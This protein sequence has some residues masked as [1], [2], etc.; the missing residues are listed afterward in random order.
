MSSH[1]VYNSAT[2]AAIRR[3]KQTTPHGLL[4]VGPTGVGLMTAAQDIAGT[5]IAGVISPTT[6]DGEP[7]SEKGTIRVEQIR[8]LYRQTRTIAS[9]D[10]VYI[11][12]QADT[13]NHS[14][15]NA[16][17]KLLEEPNEHIKFILLAHKPQL[18]LATVLS[19]VQ[20]VTVL[21]IDHT[22]S[23][24]LLNSLGITDESTIQKMLFLA[25]GLPGELT[26]LVEDT[27][28]FS[29]QAKN[30]GDARILL[31]GSAY[32]KVVLIHNYATDRVA[33]LTLLQSALIIMKR[34]L[35]SAPTK[36]LIER[37]EQY[38]AAHSAISAN[39]NVRIHLLS[40]VV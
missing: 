32:E 14:A 37:C 26:R 12:D 6:V 33:A 39:G 27:A 34:S 40:L 7:D 10:Q 4:L 35:S 23:R 29:V 21:P 1:H 25:E 13:M 36:E 31:Q 28:Y 24:Q 18:L 5:A 38:A 20:Q 15:Q 2:V 17:L 16:F 22:Q 9:H 3:L 30:I 11:L 8:E 19:R